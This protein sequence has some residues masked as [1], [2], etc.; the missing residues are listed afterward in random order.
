MVLLSST[1][2]P[3]VLLRIRLSPRPNNTPPGPSIVPACAPS[4]A[5]TDISHAKP[6]KSVPH[7]ECDRVHG[8]LWLRA[9]VESRLP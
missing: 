9:A 2:S 7:K 8:R 5:R 1:R 4:R 6:P 3:C